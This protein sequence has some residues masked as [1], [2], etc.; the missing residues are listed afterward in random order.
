MPGSEG[1]AVSGSDLAVHLRDRYGVDVSEVE[2]LD[3]GVH[4]VERADGPAWVARVFPGARPPDDVEAEAVLLRAL[5]GGGFPAERCAHPEPVSRW[6]ER[7]VLVTGFVEPAAPIRP[8][9][10][11]ALLGALLGALHDHA[12]R[13]QRS[14]GAW[15]HLSLTGGP[16]EEIAAAA[17]LLDEAVGTV[18]ARRLAMFDRLREAV[19]QADDCSD[20]PHALVHPDFVLANA[21]PTPDQT[22]VIVDWTGAGRGPP[23]WSLGFLLWAS[24]ARHPRLIDLAVSRYRRRISLEPEELARLEGAIWGRPVMLD[25]WSF[26]QGRLSLEDAAERLDSNRQL[27]QAI[28]AH[29]RTAFAAAA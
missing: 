26:C 2:S 13:G 7:T 12:G 18:P 23:L 27:A 25:C 19:E 20:L 17:E 1:S 28:A 14:G 8:G 21:I 16:R 24:G 29:A 5:E 22:L 10:S 4:R 9:R 15:H 11:A 3:L 6:G